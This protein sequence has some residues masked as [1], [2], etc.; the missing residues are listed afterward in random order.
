M[1]NEDKPKKGWGVIYL[2]TCTTSKKMLCWAG[3]KLCQ[4]KYTMGYARKMEKPSTRS[5]RKERRSL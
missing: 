1:A 4:R 3:N 2:I 5:H